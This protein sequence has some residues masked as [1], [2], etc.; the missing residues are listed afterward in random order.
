MPWHADHHRS[1]ANF[2]NAASRMCRMHLWVEVPGVHVPRKPR[3]PA[4]HYV[5]SCN[6]GLP[7]ARECHAIEPW[8]EW[9]LH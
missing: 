5:T 2:P 1:Y 3:T 4:V 9:P 7:R 6:R 8:E